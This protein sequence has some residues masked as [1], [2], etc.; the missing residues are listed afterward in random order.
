MPMDRLTT[1]RAGTD[2][3]YVFGDEGP[4]PNINHGA[5]ID[6]SPAVWDYLG[7]GSLHLV[8][9]DLLSKPMYRLHRGHCTTA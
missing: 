6:V 7:L 8:D 4:S 9:G 5:G 1:A 3:A 2:L